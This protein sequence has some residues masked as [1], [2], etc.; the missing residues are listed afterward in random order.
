MINLIPRKI[1]FSAS[2][3]V[4]PRTKEEKD[5]DYVS[6]N[7]QIHKYTLDNE[8][9]T[10]QINL[11]EQEILSLVSYCQNSGIDERANIEKKIETKREEIKNLRNQIEKNRAASINLWYGY[12]E[13]L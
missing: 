11:L 12:H 13:R 7:K 9:L 6:I 3:Y 2:R 4:P 10:Q 8:E 1:S 5:R